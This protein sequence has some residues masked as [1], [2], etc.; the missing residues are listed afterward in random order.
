M[1][2][3]K[4]VMLDL[5]F[6]TRRIL[7]LEE[8]ELR[9]TDSALICK[10]PNYSLCDAMLSTDIV[11]PIEYLLSYW[12]CKSGKSACF[13]FKNTGCR[14]SLSCYLGFPDRLKD[15]G[16][17]SDF[18]FLGANEAVIVTL[19]DIERIK[20]CDRG[21]LT[22]CVIRK[23]NSTMVFNI[24]VVAFGP[25]NE[26]EY[27][28]LLRD[29]YMRSR[30]GVESS[31]AKRH[32]CGKMETNGRI[33]TL[34]RWGTLRRHALYLAR[35]H[36][37]IRNGTAGLCNNVIVKTAFSDRC[38]NFFTRHAVFIYLSV[39][40]IIAVLLFVVCVAYWYAAYT[41]SHP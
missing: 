6:N 3:E 10:N 12:E 38:F 8:N 21:V 5:I 11:Y 37:R 24:E 29:I 17:V 15:L 36:S 39:I 25:E 9:I 16:R 41:K 33:P 23:S 1:N 14:V 7:R 4:S 2:I 19:G 30:M 32:S 13:V 26:T 27:E 40:F 31:V 34:R 18:N 35:K 22:N 28:E 20:P